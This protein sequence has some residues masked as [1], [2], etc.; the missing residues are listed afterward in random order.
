MMLKKHY[1]VTARDCYPLLTDLAKSKETIMAG[2]ILIPP[3]H[4][5]SLRL[6]IPVEMPADDAHCSGNTFQYS[7][8]LIY[9]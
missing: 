9:M 2:P 5:L 6:E 7:V 4:T 3:R 8:V 1:R